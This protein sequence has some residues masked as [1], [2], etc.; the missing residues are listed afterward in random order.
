VVVM[1]DQKEILEN[2]GQL[3]EQKKKLQALINILTREGILREEDLE[4]EFSSL[5]NLEK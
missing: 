5:L 2:R 3:I 4:E 1:D